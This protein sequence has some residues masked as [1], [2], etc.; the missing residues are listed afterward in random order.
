MRA[1]GIRETDNLLGGRCR[2]W[3]KRRLGTV[4]AL[5][6]LRSSAW[7]GIASVPANVLSLVVVV[8]LVVAW[9]C[10][11][12]VPRLLGRLGLCSVRVLFT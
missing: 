5:E 8:V 2:D 12:V 10:R 3:A 6:V 1:P 11:A 9:R 7:L 4:L